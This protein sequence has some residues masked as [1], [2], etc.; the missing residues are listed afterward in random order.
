MLIIT[1]AS[2]QDYNSNE[3]II[4]NDRRKRLRANYDGIFFTL[5]LGL[6]FLH[7]HDKLN[8]LISALR[9]IDKC[10]GKRNCAIDIT[11]AIWDCH[12]ITNNM[13]ET[14]LERRDINASAFFLSIFRCLGIKSPF[15][16]FKADMEVL[17][18]L[19]ISLNTSDLAG[20]FGSSMMS[21]NPFSYPVDMKQQNYSVQQ[22]Y[23]DMMQKQNKMMPTSTENPFVV[24]AMNSKKEVTL[25]EVKDAENTDRAIDHVDR[26]YIIPLALKTP[27]TTP[28]PRKPA[29]VPDSSPNI[30]DLKRHILMLQNLTKNDENFQSKFVVFPSLQ[31]NASTTTT[32]TT[33]TSTTTSTTST[34]TRRP[35]PTRPTISRSNYRMVTPRRRPVSLNVPKSAPKDEKITIVPQ[36]FLQN[37]QTPMNDDSFERPADDS[38]NYQGS[39]RREV[40]VSYQK[41]TKTSAGR[42][43]DS[44]PTFLHTTERSPN[45]LGRRN[46]NANSRPTKKAK[47]PGRNGEKQ[48]RRQMRKQ[49]KQEP[50]ERQ[51]NCT[52]AFEMKFNLSSSQ[53]RKGPKSNK[54]GDSAVPMSTTEFT[55]NGSRNRNNHVPIRG[56][57]PN[58]PSKRIASIDDED[59]AALKQSILQRTIRSHHRHQRRN[60]T[61][62]FLYASGS[63]VSA[64]VNE[65][66]AEAAAAAYNEHID[67]NPD[68]CYKVGGLSFGQQKLCVS[69]TQI[70]P[71]VSRGA[72]AA[73][74]VIQYSLFLS[75]SRLLFSFA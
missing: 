36:V 52:K 15:I 38:Y 26:K 33:T 27:T 19:S 24:A 21:G 32:T 34:T 20:G 22:Q 23:F 47:N 51:A 55:P 64:A 13:N 70:M 71:A 41:F 67:L 11:S 65:T 46:Q 40:R 44:R 10:S 62:D 73:I 57:A 17:S 58:Y 72:R 54:N 12:A 49:C 69:H 68:L 14:P 45:M 30:D 61:R 16:E 18:N 74:Q 29:M 3:F 6:G 48:L 37:D 50:I 2:R 39:N 75:L 43:D 42:L 9:W 5:N 66:S 1:N 35:I 7:G 60:A 56:I 59:E 25:I 31:R 53:N 4:A 63:P 8:W 28:L